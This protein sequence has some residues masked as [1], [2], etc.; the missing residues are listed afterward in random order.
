MYKYIYIYISIYIKI[1]KN[2]LL[3]QH[4]MGIPNVAGIHGTLY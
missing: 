4:F 1:L 2:P 3:S